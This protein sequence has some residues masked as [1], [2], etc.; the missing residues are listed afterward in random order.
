MDQQYLK[1]HV[2]EIIKLQAAFRGYQARKYIQMLKSKNVGS[3]K[4][5]TYEESTETLSTKKQFD[6]N[7]K[8][9]R[10]PAYNF[11][12]G[13]IYSGEWKGGFRDGQGEQ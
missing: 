2:K 12:S 9:E 11:K 10:R 6:P 3:S 7:Q 5:F 13:A 4:Y 1:R 8:R